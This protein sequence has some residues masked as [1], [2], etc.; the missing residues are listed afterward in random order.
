MQN[1]YDPKTMGGVMAVWGLAI[2]IGQSL[3]PVVM[4]WSF[5]KCDY[6]GSFYT[7]AIVAA[8]NIIILSIGIK[9]SK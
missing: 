1:S 9:D 6:H 5:S 8:L 7:G 3:G 4:G 2:R